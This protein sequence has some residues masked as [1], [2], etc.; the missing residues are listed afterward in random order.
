MQTSL[1]KRFQQTL[2]ANNSNKV[3]AN[4]QGILPQSH[5][6]GRALDFS[7]SIMDENLTL[8]NRA[9]AIVKI[10]F[11]QDPLAVISEVFKDLT[12]LLSSKRSDTK[13]FKEFESLF[14]AQISKFN[15]HSSDPKLPESF[16]CFYL[17]SERKC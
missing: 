1:L 16:N 6:Y 2:P 7:K 5:L 17:A 8:V 4:L 9:D 3:P 14:S 11:K 13:E 10:I 15:S 12:V